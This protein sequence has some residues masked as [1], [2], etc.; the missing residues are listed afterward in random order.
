MSHEPGASAASRK[1][2]RDRLLNFAKIAVSL[3]GLAALLLTKLDVEQVWQRLLDTD[4]LLFLVA[5]ALFLSGAL[6]RA[7]RWG[8]LVWALGIRVSWWRLA[9]LVFVGTFFGLFL[10]TGIGGDAIKMYELSRDDHKA[11]AAISSVV[12]DRFL[13]LFVLFAM[14]LLV[15]LGGYRMVEP[16]YRIIIAAIFAVCLLAVALLLQ[17]TWIEAWGRRL[18]LDRL[19]GRVKILRELYE[20]VHLYGPA[21]LARS[22]LASVVWNLILILGYYCLGR[23]VGIDLSL[24]YYFLFVPIISSLLLVPSVGGLGI[25]EGGTVV[26]FGQVVDENHAAALALTFDLTLL[27]T[28]L[29]GALLY[30]IQGV[31][32]ARN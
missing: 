31:R 2:Q 14:A 25:R 19:L 22:T 11:A 7:Y 13:G 9:E 20:S 12:V 28:G 8:A 26:L 27:I 16:Q 1:K 3:A 30:V 21:A 15:L 6:V 17:R 5:L 4:W 32:E 24:W 10:P 23:A 18:G 29:I